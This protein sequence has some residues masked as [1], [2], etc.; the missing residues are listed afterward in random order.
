MNWIDYVGYIVNALIIAL[1]GAIV[2]LVRKVF[3]NEK[4]IAMFAQKLK[5]VDRIEEEVKELRT[6]IKDILFKLSDN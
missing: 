4:G 6:D 1:V 3:T 5:A 2:A